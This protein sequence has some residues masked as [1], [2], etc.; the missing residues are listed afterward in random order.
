[1]LL[2]LNPMHCLAGVWLHLEFQVGPLRAP[3]FSTPRTTPSLLRPYRPSR[4]R[5]LLL[6]EACSTAR[7][8]DST[9]QSEYARMAGGVP[10]AMRSLWGAGAAGHHARAIDA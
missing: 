3:D 2:D 7:S 5:L 4:P 9:A 10:A 6:E 8:L 1:M